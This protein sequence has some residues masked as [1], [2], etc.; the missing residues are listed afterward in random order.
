LRAAA[1]ARPVSHQPIR[2]GRTS[3]HLADGVHA[4]K[5]A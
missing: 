3:E 1:M 5:T 4:Q 2:T